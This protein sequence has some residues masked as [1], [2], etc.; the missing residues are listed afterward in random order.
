MVPT[1]KLVVVNVATSFATVPLPIMVVPLK[2]FMVP[3]GAAGPV[4]AGVIVAVNVTDVPKAGELG[5]T[6]RAVD[7][8]CSRAKGRSIEPKNVYLRSEMRPRC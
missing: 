3:E 5:V 4:L 2:K 7:R 6:V 8:T 1:S